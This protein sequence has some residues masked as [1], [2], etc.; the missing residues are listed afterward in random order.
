ME[1]KS[2][3]ECEKFRQQSLPHQRQTG[4]WISPSVLL[5]LCK[6]WYFCN[7]A[8]TCTKRNCCENRCT[9]QTFLDAALPP[10]P[11]KC[12]SKEI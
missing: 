3:A 10:L 1:T 6:L 5:G 7:S 9:V 11:P 2:I 8:V 4:R 12:Y